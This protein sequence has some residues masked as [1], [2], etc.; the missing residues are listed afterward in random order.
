[1]TKETA[2]K[3]LKELHDNSLFSNRIA[4]EVLIPEL[5]DSNDERIRKCLI[6][7]FEDWHENRSHCW[8]IAVTAIL[9]WLE[10]QGKSSDQIH[11]WTEEEIEPIIN[12]YL[13]GVEH[14][15]GM[16]GRLRC[17]K[18]KSLEKQGGNPVPININKMVMEYSQTK[19]GDFGLPVNCQIRAYRQGINDALSLSLNLEKQGTPV[20]LDEKE[21]Q[22]AK[23]KMFP[24]Q[25][26]VGRS[27]EQ[28]W[29]ASGFEL[30]AHFVLNR[31]KNNGYSDEIYKQGEFGTF[32]APQTPI[33]DAVEVTS[34][35]PFISN[36]MKPIAEFIMGYANWDLHKD[37]W[38]QPTLTVPLFR[39]L[40]ALIQRGKPYG[41]CSQNIEKQGEQ[42]P[43]SNTRYKVSAGG[44]LIVVDG[45]PFDYEHATITQKD[46]APKQEPKKTE[47]E[48]EIPFG[49][50]DSELIEE[51]Y[52]IPKGCNVEVMDGCAAI[53]KGEKPTAW[54]DEDEENLQHCCM[55]ISVDSL[56]TYED[57][58]DMEAW[59][60][61]L[62]NRIG[63]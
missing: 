1:M 12:D 56:H 10:K 49:A 3:I 37:E 27:Y 20:K 25:E 8:G 47:D 32:D 9:A 54:S 51:R 14:Y 17:L 7:F 39:V 29:A 35:M 55:A 59:L 50:K 15:G 5:A 45:K 43:T 48:I 40:D 16:I 11:Y 21:I 31:L 60:K 19:D 58:Q 41:E 52:Y 24:Y 26:N 23:D 36:D 2:M 44:S 61:R 62:K 34:R 22:T 53:K 46:F 42:K 38:S 63:G 33:K 18:P 30:G 13:R 28:A 57:K 4:L 6:D